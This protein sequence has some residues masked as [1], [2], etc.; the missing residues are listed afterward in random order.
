MRGTS[1]KITGLGVLAA[2]AAAPSA[3]AA[4][5]GG[6]PFDADHGP[7]LRTVTILEDNQVNTDY[8]RYCFDEEI[9]N[10][11]IDDNGFQLRGYDSSESRVSTDAALELGAGLQNC[12]RVTFGGFLGEE[13]SKFTV[14]SVSTGAVRDVTGSTLNRADA[15]G[16]S[17]TTQGNSAGDTARA[18]LVS[19][20]SDPTLNQLIFYFDRRLLAAD[21]NGFGYYDEEGNL[22]VSNDAAI[23]NITGGSRVTVTF[24][25]AGGFWTVRDAV[26]AI[27]DTG[28]VADQDGDLNLIQS[29]VID[30]EDEGLTDGLTARPDLVGVNISGP[31]SVDFQFDGDQPVKINNVGE[32]FI[33]DADNNFTSA[34]EAVVLQETG[35]SRIVR[36]FFDVNGDIED[37][38]LRAWVDEGAVHSNGTVVGIENTFGGLPIGSIPGVSGYTNAPDAQ[39][40]VPDADSAGI[41]VEFDQD[42]RNH[43]GTGLFTARGVNGN[44]LGNPSS[45]TIV[46]G[47]TVRL[48]FASA[49]IVNST[50]GIDLDAGA[51][52][53]AR[54][55]DSVQQIIGRSVSA[56]KPPAPPA[57]GGGGGGGTPGTPAPAAAAPAAAGQQVA[58][59]SGAA[60]TARV[61]PAR[62]GSSAKARVLYAKYRKGSLTTKVSGKAKKVKIRI[63]LRG[64]K[65]KTVKTV[66]RTI[67]TNRQ[68][69]LKNLTRSS[70]VKS[71]RVRVL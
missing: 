39:A 70:K 1:L 31:N 27:V 58:G 56:P 67:R 53:G 25:T 35:N 69:T 51:V 45:V 29:S 65:G 6:T 3:H 52:E 34:F 19:V 63:T 43:N 68:V 46:D 33:W 18:D 12:V 49:G 11:P 42:V 9:R 22:R 57:A 24:P 8:A 28:S 60:P 54:G 48:Q 61:S 21:D 10:T 32:F 4:L 16:V 41:T 40:M 62:S 37:Y 64:A 23:Q 44:N 59:Q 14:G 5:A 2:L 20:E 17:N 38:D 71:V 66:T 55:D 15:T 13:I 7:D 26:R 36:A 47:N 50:R 30:Q